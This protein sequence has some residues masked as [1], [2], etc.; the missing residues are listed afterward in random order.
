ML[1]VANGRIV[2]DPLSKIGRELKAADDFFA[3]AKNA[4][5]PKLMV[6]SLT[7]RK[8]MTTLP[9]LA[10][11]VGAVLYCRNFW[12]EAPGLGLYL[13]A[14]Q[15][16]L[17]GEPL[18]SCNPAFTYPPIFAFV[19]IPLV[20]LPLV[21]QNLIWYLVTLGSIV[22]C[23]ILSARMT[24]IIVPD[25]WSERDLAWL[26]G[27]GVLLNLKFIFAALS[28]QSYDAS[29][30][31]LV[32]VGIMALATDRPMW[33]GAS[34]A[35]AAA[36]KA[37]PLLFLPYLVAKQHYRAAA[38]MALALAAACVLP[39]RIFAIAGGP[40]GGSY[41][42]DWLLQVAQPALIEK[43]DGNPITFWLASNTDNNS[44]RG[45]VGMWFDDFNPAFGHVLYA[46]YAVYCIALALVLRSTGNGARAAAID[47]SLLLISMLLLSPMT[48][49]SHHI[50]LVLPVFAIVATWV[51]GGGSPRRTAGLLLIAS[52]I[53]TNASSKD[54][55]GQTVTL[56]AKEYRLIVFN[57]LLLAA[58]FPILAFRRQSI[59]PLKRRRNP[60]FRRESSRAREAVAPRPSL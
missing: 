45:L 31:L 44:V 59:P 15:C 25:D 28:N 35:C 18:Q 41:L 46:V 23:V 49:Q 19:M 8:L 39:D 6:G 11:A 5:S 36:L 3:L 56:W 29:V 1:N 34:L 2:V 40:A 42:L 52:F 48:S 50:A 9:W 4:S 32:L 13:E 17:R 21:L 30:V 53:L 43:L 12:D 22:G 47:G 26:Y 20:P 60:S 33:A 57:A 24:Q 55:V 7:R 14:A 37:T 54:I 10:I 16:M 51:K 58:F 27:L 38:V